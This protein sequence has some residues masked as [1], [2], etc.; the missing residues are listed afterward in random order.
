MRIGTQIRVLGIA[1]VLATAGMLGM[2][3]YWGFGKLV[4]DLRRDS[5]ERLARA[6][7][8]R[9][10]GS[11]TLLRR[12]VDLL[13]M[14][15]AV[16][17]FAVDADPVE[18]A[19]IGTVMAQLSRGRPFYSQLRVIGIA[20][21]GREV[22]R[23]NRDG[24][25]VRLASHDDLQRKGDRDY[26]I[27]AVKQTPGTYYLSR[28]ELNRENGELEIPYRPVVRAA[29]PIAG[30]DGA[31]WGIVVINV[32]IAR[33]LDFIM[34]ERKGARTVRLTNADGDYLV[35]ENDAKSFGFDLG[36]RHRLPLEEPATAALFAADAKPGATATLDWPGDEHPLAHFL[37]IEV[38][39]MGAAHALVLGIIATPSGL[40]ANTTALV[41]RGLVVTGALLLF[42]LVL[43]HYG[44]RVVTRPIDR[45]GAA[46]RAVSRGETL[47]VDLPTRRHDEI[48]DLARTF[49]AMMETLRAKQ[50]ELEGANQRMEVA[51][52]D[53]DH[54]A[55]VAAHD[56]REPARRMTALADLLDQRERERLSDEGRRGI[57][58]L[59]VAADAMLQQI[60]GFR[61]LVDLRQSDVV[62]TTVDLHLVVREI[63]E[64]LGTELVD[65]GFLV[66]I[67]ELPRVNVYE[68]LVGVLVRKLVLHAIAHARAPSAEMRFSSERTE[69][70]PRIAM[71]V[72]MQS[73]EDG[74]TGRT[75]T[76]YN[77]LAIEAMSADLGFVIA[78]RIVERHSGRLE[79][80]SGDSHVEIRFTL[81][82]HAEVP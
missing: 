43:S 67:D 72:T 42:A 68:H 81:G 1:L 27:E 34:P 82:R 14:I 26:F 60:T 44:T 51:L 46:A 32:D 40:A 38:E 79:I 55:H 63:C 76:A 80:L 71:R 20:D 53:L 75:G 33:L 10:Q 30:A 9:I 35:H 52:R 61:E 3:T 31:T 54:F 49:S 23:V 66:T 11:F 39:P 41:T 58:R 21:G 56:L 62:R 15:P 16:R 19:R 57:D 4:G 29:V 6:H 69:D 78:R 70:G 37:R 28:I 36:H 59:R 5:I 12:D 48:G 18:L 8:D 73:G 17:E 45:I 22:V 65:A 7:A 64:E 2:V 25:D 47:P 74:G 77:P 50:A 13:A 24:D